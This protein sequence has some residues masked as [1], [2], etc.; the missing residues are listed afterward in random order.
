MDSFSSE[1]VASREVL[2][3][4]PPGYEEDGEP[5]SVLY[6]HD[7]QNVFDPGRSWTGDEWRV[8]E[9]LS[10]MIARN[11]IEPLIVVAIANSG[12]T[13]WNEYAPQKVISAWRSDQLE[14]INSAADPSFFGTETRPVDDIPL[15]ADNY[16]NFLVQ[17]LKPHID[18]NY[19][20]QP[21]RAHTF[22]AG[23]SMGGLISLYAISEYPSVFGAAACLSMHWPIGR[24]QSPIAQST[25]PYF[26]DY[27]STGGFDP[28]LHRLWIDR[29]TE[30]LDQFYEPYFDQMQV[31]F[32]DQYP[33]L[34]S[35]VRF[36]VYEGTD[37]SEEAWSKR[38]G[39]VAA[40]LLE[41]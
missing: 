38:F 30:T 3:W 5:Y 35:R 40:F 4:L 24:P 29:G 16:L 28:V 19:H 25:I 2:I 9:T 22:I 14:T 36:S 7:G 31:W 39:E 23:S 12:S 1:F 13:R 34:E 33:D 21:E 27:L 32:N 17:E 26:Q 18:L 10:A 41:R 11:E 8:D 15:L 37:H 20:T 6:M